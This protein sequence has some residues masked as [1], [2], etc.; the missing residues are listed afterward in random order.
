[1]DIFQLIAILVAL[2]AAYFIISIMIVSILAN[3]PRNAVDEEPDWG[4]TEDCRIPTVNG[5]SLECWI[6]Y[7]EESSKSAECEKEKLAIILL[8]GWG[9]NRGRMVSRARFFGQKGHTT[10]L[11]SAR[12]HGSSDKEFTG[13]NIL[14]FSQDLEATLNWWGKPAILAGHSI[15]GGAALLVAA[16]NPLAKAVIAE[17]PPH[18][19]SQSL[20]YVYWPALRWFTPIFLPG[21]IAFNL[22]RYRG[23]Q[24]EYYSPLHAAPRIKVPTFL[25]HGMNDDLFPY[26]YTLELAEKLNC[27]VWTPEDI[28]HYDIENHPDYARKITDFVE[29][30]S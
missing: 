29:S 3:F 13:M 10:I 24:R 27:K 25:I 6:V 4:T 17:A 16:R 22:I 14:R 8:H 9:R 15:G 2:M 23:Y 18:A 5:K 11:I 12:D 19:I 20:K 30:L 21:I 26:E 7:P 1:M 28:T